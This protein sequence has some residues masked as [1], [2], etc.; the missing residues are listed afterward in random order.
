MAEPGKLHFLINQLD[1]KFC[2]MLTVTMATVKRTK[3]KTLVFRTCLG[4]GMN[5]AKGLGGILI[6][7]EG[8]F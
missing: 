4:F 7:R 8:L 2:E 6:N 5:G 3:N 1:E